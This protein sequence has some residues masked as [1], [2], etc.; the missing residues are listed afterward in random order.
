MTSLV[1]AD[2]FF[3]DFVVGDVFR[4]ARGKTITDFETMTLAQLM[5]NTS[6]GHYNADRMRDSE[7]GGT[8][9]FGGVVA[10]VVYGLA[11][12]DTAEQA[13]E[14]LGI[15]RI[16]FQRPTKTGDTLYAV[17][18]VLEAEARD[19]ASGTVRFRHRGVNQD[20]ATVCELER[21]V[22]VRRRPHGEPAR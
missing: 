1:G 12:Q 6:D 2:N 8:L 18:E 22:L 13:L 3:E 10:S 5:M 15:D 21:R 14:E 19:A 20:G 16:R 7:F 9:T 17:T 11:S 4:H